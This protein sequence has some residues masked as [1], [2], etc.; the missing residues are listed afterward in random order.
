M[1]SVWITLIYVIAQETK[2]R[3]YPITCVLHE[4]RH[5]QH[6][7]STDVWS[8]SVACRGKIE[9]FSMKI[10]YKVH[11]FAHSFQDTNTNF[12]FGLFSLV[13]FVILFIAWWYWFRAP[14]CSGKVDMQD[15]YEKIIIRCAYP[16]VKP[17]LNLRRL[18]I[19]KNAFIVG[20]ALGKMPS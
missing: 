1:W 17:I 2:R 16:Q 10:K 20:C 19:R 5:S 13:S 7:Y 18:C 14:M 9:S 4:T 3:C 15:F 6:D 8:P 12:Y 11:T